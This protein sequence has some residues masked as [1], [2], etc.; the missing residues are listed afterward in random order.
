MRIAPSLVLAAAVPEF[1]ARSAGDGDEGDVHT[2]T[3]KI[4]SDGNPVGARLVPP[5]LH[6][7]P[8]FSRSLSAAPSSLFQ[9]NKAQSDDDDEVISY[10]NIIGS[11]SRGRDD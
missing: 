1:K 4:E 2:C 9:R 7:S 6:P 8:C 11:Q 5:S 3:A 10:A